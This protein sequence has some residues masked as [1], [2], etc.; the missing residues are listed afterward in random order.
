MTKAFILC[1]DDDRT[2]L[3]SL[4]AQLKHIYGSRFAYEVAESGH[5]AWEVIRQIYDNGH[6]IVAIISDWLMP[7]IKGD[8]FLIQVHQEFPDI[9][10]IMLTGQA[11]SG[12]VRRAEQ[13]ANLACCVGKPWDIKEI[14]KAIPETK[15]E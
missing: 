14:I 7:G 6:H 3:M 13:F 15:H 5:E 4:R 1:V 12:A 8:E 11:D 2:I 9:T 10:K